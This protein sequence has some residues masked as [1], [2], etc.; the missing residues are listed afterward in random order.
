MLASVPADD[1]KDGGESVE[2]DEEAEA[3][4]DGGREQPGGREAVSRVE[5]SG[6][7]HKAV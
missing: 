2:R 1:E 6:C 4:E 3:G 5:G 7:A